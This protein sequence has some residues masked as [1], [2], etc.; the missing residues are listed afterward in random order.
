[1]KVYE[2]DK[3]MQK[4]VGR[5]MTTIFLFILLIDYLKKDKIITEEYH[6]SLLDKLK[7]KVKKTIRFIK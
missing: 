3:N 5:V 2:R 6:I 7:A 4:S 1:M